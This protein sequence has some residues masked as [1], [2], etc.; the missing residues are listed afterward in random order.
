MLLAA[1]W[2]P[3]HIPPLVGCWHAVQNK[4]GDAQALGKSSW[5]PLSR[6]VNVMAAAPALS[7][8]SCLTLSQSTYLLVRRHQPPLT[9]LSG[10]E[11]Q[12]LGRK[13]PE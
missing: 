5:S 6:G 1:D 7:L 8:L 11:K 10:C 2:G 3:E 4:G 12:M 9:S 13:T